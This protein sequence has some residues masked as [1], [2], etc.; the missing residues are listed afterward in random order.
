MRYV[1]WSKGLDL[2]CLNSSCNHLMKDHEID[3]EVADDAPP[4]GTRVAGRCRN[5]PCER[6][7]G[8]AALYFTG[9]VRAST[10]SDSLSEA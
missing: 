9:G 7:R 4:Y 2:P 6:F 10:A 1:Q 3:L 5:C 8:P